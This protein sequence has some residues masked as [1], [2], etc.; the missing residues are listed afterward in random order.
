MSRGRASWLFV[1][2]VVAAGI[3]AQGPSAAALREELARVQATQDRLLTARIRYDLGL[4]VQAEPYF[5]LVEA[6]RGRDRALLE[7]QLVEEQARVTTLGARLATAETKLAQLRQQVAQ[8]VGATTPLDGA[9][10]A[11]T[12]AARPATEPF[13]LSNEPPSP[14]AETAPAPEPQRAKAAA[15]GPQPVLLHGS[16]D[17]SRVGRALFLARN[18]ERARVELT[19]AAAVDGG[20]DLMDLFYLARSCEALGDTA[21]AD[22]LYLQIESRDTTEVKGQK[23]P[24]AWAKAARVARRQMQWMANNA[25]WQPA[26]GI[27]SVPWRSR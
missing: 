27:D 16:R 3:A 20:G 23:Q 15:D 2:L 19:A 4:P 5:A 9:P 11:S 25:H 12:P 24:G 26:R 21:K 14:A 10:A 8:V 13:A 18:Y 1:P 6:E 22:E 7:K 17:H